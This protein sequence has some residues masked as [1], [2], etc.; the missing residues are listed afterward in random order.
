M[1][2]L[3]LDW[4]E[5]DN[6]LRTISPSDINDSVQLLVRFGKMQPA[7]V[8]CIKR[9][10]VLLETNTFIDHLAL[11]YSIEPLKLLSRTRKKKYRIVR[12]IGM[13]YLRE[14]TKMTT[15]DIADLFNRDHST[16]SHAYK[17]I[18]SEMQYDTYLRDKVNKLIKSVNNDN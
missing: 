18:A 10:L 14:N 6:T 8:G 12:Q 4:C 7:F 3:L 9:A 15:Y 1:T 5:N 17:V 16:V 2:K 11:V 13:W